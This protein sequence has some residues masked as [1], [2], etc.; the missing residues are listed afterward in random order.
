MCA[1][2]IYANWRKRYTNQK[3]QKKFWNC[4]KSSCR[5]LF[6][7]NR[8]KLVQDTPQGAKDM[9]TT[10]PEHWSRAFFQLGSNCDSVDNNMCESFNNSIMDSRFFPVISMNE[11]IRCKVMVRI[12]DNRTKAD[13]WQGTICPNIFK[14]L[15]LNIERSGQCYVLWNGQHGFEVQE[16]EKKKYTVN[17]GQKTCSRRYWQLLGLPCCHAISAIYKASKQLDDYIA[18]SFSISE[19]M[20]TYQHC[21]QPVEGQDKWPVSDMTKP[22][23]P[24]Y[25]KM[26]GRPKTQ[27]T[28]EPTEKPKGAKVSKVGIKMRCKLCHQTS[29]NSRT[30][31]RNKEDGSKRNGY[32]RR[33]A[34]R[35]RKQSEAT[36][37]AAATSFT[38]GDVG[39]QQS[40][41][42]SSLPPS[43]AAPS[44]APLVQQKCRKRARPA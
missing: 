5:E 9:I 26:P 10:A 2:H 44:S 4:A 34:T 17:L 8:A 16:K 3:L 7:Y 32:I 39:T 27:R 38:M 22:H 29:H 41:S 6:N 23:P 15:K 37:S 35:K 42:R 40:I 12:A 36:T 33:D 20:N 1:R 30:C 18:S 21:L 24:A 11:A 31:A 14:K 28:R 43:V 25:V 19:Y 13:K